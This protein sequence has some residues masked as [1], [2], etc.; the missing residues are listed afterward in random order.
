MLSALHSGTQAYPGWNLFSGGLQ[1]KIHNYLGGLKKG[2]SRSHA[3]TYTENTVINPSFTAQERLKHEY[4]DS[5]ILLC[6]ADLRSGTI[7][8]TLFWS[9]PVYMKAAGNILTNWA[10]Q[11]CLCRWIY[12]HITHYTSAFFKL[13]LKSKWHYEL[14]QWKYISVSVILKLKKLLKPL[15]I[16]FTSTVPENKRVQFHIAL[17]AQIKHLINTFWTRAFL[18]F[19]HSI[20]QKFRETDNLDHKVTNFLDIVNP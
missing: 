2:R 1:E 18:F 6:L 14:K 8:L 5:W 13:D 16:F 3:G 9:D 11:P 4:Y 12:M 10:A 7:T 20:F 17:V 15:S 19:Q